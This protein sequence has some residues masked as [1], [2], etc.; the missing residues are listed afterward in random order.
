MANGGQ[1]KTRSERV[2]ALELP[3]GRLER[4]WLGLCH[5]DMLSRLALAFVA[6]VAVC[7]IIQAW[8][9]PLHWRTGMVH[10][11]YFSSRVSFQREDHEATLKAQQKRPRR[12]DGR[13]Q[14]GYEAAG[15]IAGPAADDDRRPHQ[16]GNAERFDA[17][18]VE[19]IPAAS[20]GE[21]GKK[22]HVVQAGRRSGRIQGVSQRTGRQ[23]QS[24]STRSRRR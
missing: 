22:R 11:R 17:E 9:P 24:R 16:G 5:R 21:A 19:R 7:L 6:A 20:A 4:A 12:N 8:D 15:A 1:R 14:P 10:T 3:P 18:A 23:G 2:A 13:V